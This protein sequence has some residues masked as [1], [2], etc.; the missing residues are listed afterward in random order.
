[1]CAFTERPRASRFSDSEALRS[2]FSDRFG[3]KY[4]PE[5]PTED[6]YGSDLVSSQ[7]AFSSSGLGDYDAR[8]ASILQRDSGALRGAYGLTGA[9]QTTLGRGSLNMPG[10]PGILGPSPN[11]TVPRPF[12][13]S[14]Q[15]PGSFGGGY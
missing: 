14:R 13:P 4:E 12:A 6:T 7:S 5:E 8:S 9:N 11:R 15:M 3:E 1:M 2:S 10:R